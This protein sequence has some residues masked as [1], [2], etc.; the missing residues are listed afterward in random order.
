MKV[1]T[2]AVK[3]LTAAPD[4]IEVALITARQRRYSVAVIIG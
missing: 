2:V 4:R 3:I 1:V